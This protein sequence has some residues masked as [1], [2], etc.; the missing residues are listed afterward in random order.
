MNAHTMKE[1]A[2]VTFALL[3]LLAYSVCG[4]FIMSNVKASMHDAVHASH[5]IVLMSVR[6]VK[7]S[8]VLSLHGKVCVPGPYQPRT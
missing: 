6:S 3:S 2:M 5:C 4:I 8:I 7:N 1:T